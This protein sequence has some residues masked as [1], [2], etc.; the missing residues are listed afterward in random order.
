MP[1]TVKATRDTFRVMHPTTNALMAWGTIDANGQ[2]RNI[3][4]PD[5]VRKCNPQR[6]SV[7]K[8]IDSAEKLAEAYYRSEMEAA[9]EMGTT[10]FIEDLAHWARVILLRKYFPAKCG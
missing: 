10:A 8:A 7:V 1:Y 4:L 5:A 2:P 3:D 9:K 6:L